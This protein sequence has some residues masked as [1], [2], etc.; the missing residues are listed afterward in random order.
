MVR[1]HLRPLG[2]LESPEATPW[3]RRDAVQRANSAEEPGEGEEGPGLDE[4]E[5]RR[6]FATCSTTPA[7]R[8][9]ALRAAG[10]STSASRP[11]SARAVARKDRDSPGRIP[12]RPAAREPLSASAI[13]CMSSCRMS[14]PG[15]ILPRRTRTRSGVVAHARRSRD[16]TAV[17]AGADAVLASVAVRSSPSARA[18]E[19][20]ARLLSVRHRRNAI[21]REHRILG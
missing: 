3:W 18:G 20:D 12:H 14:M 8:D 11:A 7:A 13:R 2:E 15:N 19:D 21:G 10:I 4:A 17:G 16:V 9:R 5:F 6:R 1:T